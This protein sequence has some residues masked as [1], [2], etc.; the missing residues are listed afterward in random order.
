MAV[1]ANH[2][3][4]VWHNDLGFSMQELHAM[5]Y[6]A[7]DHSFIDDDEKQRAYDRF[8]KGHGL[9]LEDGNEITFNDAIVKSREVHKAAQNT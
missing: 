8:F 7:M 1:D 9:G 5:T 6:M 4:D 2:E 3:W